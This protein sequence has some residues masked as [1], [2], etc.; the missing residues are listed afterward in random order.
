M[1]FQVIAFLL[2]LSTSVFAQIQ[3]EWIDSASHPEADVAL[4]FTNRPLEY[5]EDGSATFKNKST[6]QTDNLYFCM[7][8]YGSD[9]IHL[10]YRAENTSKQYP[11]QP[12]KNNFLYKALKD[13]RANHGITKFYFVIPGYSKTFETQ[14]YDFMYRLK[15]TYGDA[16]RKSTAIIM[17]AWGDEWRP[18]RY[19]SA[20]VSARRGGNDFAI[21]QHMLDEVVSDTGFVSTYLND[22]EVNLVCTSMGNQLLKKYLQNRAKQDIPLVKTYNNINFIGSDAAW[23]SFEE[24]K[25][26]DRIEELADTVRIYVNSKDGPLQMSQRLNPKPRMGLMGPVNPHELPGY[27]RIYLVTDLIS[28]EDLGTMGHDYLLRNP[29]IT[30]SLRTTVDVKQTSL[31]VEN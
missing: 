9:T 3:T 19:Y 22:V 6:V 21:F 7:F 31:R 2:L 18:Y 10:K 28:R 29:V 24:G 8:D 4:F 13:I 11:T 25:G 15:T 1:R 27:I 17:Y 26:F 14:V 5:K 20:K 12:V 30:E 16:L 23:D